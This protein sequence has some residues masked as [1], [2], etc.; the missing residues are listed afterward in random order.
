MKLNKAR[1]FGHRNKGKRENKTW[2]LLCRQ[3]DPLLEAM[4][5]CPNKLRSFISAL[6][7]SNNPRQI[8]FLWA[9]CLG[10]PTPWST[11][12]PA[13]TASPGP[14]AC[15]TLAQLLEGSLATPGTL[16]SSLLPTCC[17]IWDKAAAGPDGMPAPLHP[18]TESFLGRTGFLSF[19]ENT[20]IP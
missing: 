13:H 20:V 18:I 4:T 14:K 7:T 17:A 2:K 9:L 11:L 5:C 10:V 16:R 19:S 12:K 8:H 15:A 6:G 1:E 3:T